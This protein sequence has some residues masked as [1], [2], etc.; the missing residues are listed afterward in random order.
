MIV[1]FRILSIDLHHSYGRNK[2][3]GTLY[4]NHFNVKRINS[5]HEIFTPVGLCGN[6]VVQGRKLYVQ[7][8]IT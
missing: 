4:H 5:R 3:I 2:K 8:C 7:Y 1:G 6:K